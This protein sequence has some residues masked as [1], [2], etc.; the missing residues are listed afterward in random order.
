MMQEMKNEMKTQSQQHGQVLATYQEKQDQL[1]NRLA[2]IEG[3]VTPLKDLISRSMPASEVSTDRTSSN[4]HDDA[5][6]TNSI[7]DAV[8]RMEDH[9]AALPV[10]K[11]QFSHLK[12]TVEEIKTNV[13]TSKELMDPIILTDLPRIKDAVSGDAGLAKILKQVDL[14]T[15]LV[16]Q[17]V[18][19]LQT[20]LEA[21]AQSTTASAGSI[22]NTAAVIY[23]R[24][25]C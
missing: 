3:T 15:A 4:A 13:N 17:R 5:L 18:K 25:P 11:Q 19:N 14:Q 8:Q 23:Q 9:T 24:W 7:R 2:A 10:L 22:N 6:V 16:E 21:V 20:E 1:G 12:T